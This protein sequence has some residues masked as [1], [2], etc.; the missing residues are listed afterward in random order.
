MSFTYE[1]IAFVVPWLRRRNE[2]PG[3]PQSC[4]VSIAQ[5]VNLPSD[6]IRSLEDLSAS[7]IHCSLLCATSFGTSEQVL[8]FSEIKNVSGVLHNWFN[9]SP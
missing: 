9:I 1:D 3:V 8:L 6:K 2:V 5:D 4:S 7:A